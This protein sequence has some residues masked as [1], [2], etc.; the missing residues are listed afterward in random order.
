MTETTT[1]LLRMLNARLLPAVVAFAFALVFVSCG[2]GSSRSN[3]PT[4]DS[5]EGSAKPADTTRARDTLQGASRQKVERPIKLSTDKAQYRVGAEMELTLTNP[6]EARYSFNF[7]TRVVEQELNGR[8]TKV[9]ESERMCTMMAFL[10]EPGSTR[11]G[12]TELPAALSSGRYRVAISLVVEN[13]QI[14][15]NEYVVATSPSI[16]I[17]P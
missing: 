11:S 15:P 12:K 17:V 16:T 6:T 1:N 9:D 2:A 7:C 3:D 8:W 13:N 5:S 4:S 10:L 14:P